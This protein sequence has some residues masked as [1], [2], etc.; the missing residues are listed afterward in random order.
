MI[1]NTLCQI[2]PYL[3]EIHPTAPKPGIILIFLHKNFVN[4]QINF[5]YSSNI[6]TNISFPPTNSHFGH[7]THRC[8]HL[9]VCCCTTK[10]RDRRAYLNLANRTLTL[11][12]FCL[13]VKL[14]L[15]VRRLFYVSVSQENIFCA[16]WQRIGLQHNIADF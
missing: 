2:H 11:I 16:N 9:S 1:V 12:Q 7:N 8:C 5:F 15:I 10:T 13:H 14:G 6:A 4:T 3:A